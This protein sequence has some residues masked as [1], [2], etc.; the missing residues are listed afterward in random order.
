MEDITYFSPPE[1]SKGIL[2]LAEQIEYAKILQAHI[3]TTDENSV[4]QL[5]QQIASKKWAIYEFL[6]NSSDYTDWKNYE[7]NN[8]EMLT[9]YVGLDYFTNEFEGTK[10]KEKITRDFEDSLKDNPELAITKRE[11]INLRNYEE[12]SVAEIDR[13]NLDKYNHIVANIHNKEKCF[14]RNFNKMVSDL[15]S[16]MKLEVQKTLDMVKLNPLL[17]KDNPH[18]Y[19]VNR[20][21]QLTSV[22]CEQFKD[23]LEQANMGDPSSHSKMVKILVSMEQ[24][25][26]GTSNKKLVQKYREQF[27]GDNDTKAKKENNNRLSTPGL[28]TGN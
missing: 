15:P 3:I 14:S 23:I 27:F 4:M 19:I 20:E 22:S 16:K 24:L 21:N 12:N 28:K 2:E 9:K 13:Q 17:L 6:S 5:E 25:D 11:K 1:L 10:L 18:H 26:T 8:A 7:N